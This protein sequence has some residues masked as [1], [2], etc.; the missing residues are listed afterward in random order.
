MNRI[1]RILNHAAEL[2]QRLLSL[3]VTRDS[4]DSKLAEA[5]SKANR[6]DLQQIQRNLFFKGISICNYHTFENGQVLSE[7][8][9]LV[10]MLI[11]AL[12]DDLTPYKMGSTNSPVN[13]TIQ[14]WTQHILC[15]LNEK[16]HQR[17]HEG[18]VSDSSVIQDVIDLI[19]AEF[20]DNNSQYHIQQVHI[21]SSTDGS[22]SSS[23]GGAVVED[24]SRVL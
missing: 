20:Q 23:R 1:D 16:L 18:G 3:Q 6:S 17:K 15:K 4:L 22:V 13:S 19:D 14:W 7:R 21:I 11:G 9:S 5:T 24:T 8:N 12:F 10:A 2:A